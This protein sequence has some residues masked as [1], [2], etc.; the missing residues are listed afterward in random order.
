LTTREEQIARAGWAG[1]GHIDGRHPNVAGGRRPTAV[2]ISE[3]PVDEQKTLERIRRC[4][5]NPPENSKVFTITPMVAQ[6]LLRDYD[7]ENRPKKPKAIA[8]YADDMAARRWS[9]TGDPIKFSKEKKHL[10]DGQ[11]RLKACVRAGAP[12]TTYIVFGV[13]D[14]AF[15]RMDQGRNRSG[16]DVLTIVGYTNTA[17]LTPLIHHGA[18]WQPNGRTCAIKA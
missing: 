8:R 9:L 11:N 18:E 7:F 17:A 6:A 14:A 10:R 3:E 4:I 2:A 15:D 5:D 12:F 16:S 1:R 13:D